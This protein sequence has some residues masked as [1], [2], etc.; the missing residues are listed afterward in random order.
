M[1]LK[2]HLVSSAVMVVGSTLVF[3]ALYMMNSDP[4]EPPAVERSE[5][6]ALNVERTPPKRDQKRQRAERKTIKQNTAAKL[7]PTPS[8]GSALAGISFRLPGFE[9]GDLSGVGND[10]VGAGSAKNMVMTEDAVDK[11]PAPVKQNPPQFPQKARQRGLEGY[12]KLNLFINQEGLVEKVKV[13]EAEPQGVFED[14]A[15]AAAQSWEFTPAEYNGNPV[16]GWFKR[17][18]SFRLN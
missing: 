5:A 18:V 13:L 2:R 6:I 15:I 17:T 9:S 14:S 10:M 4:G 1:S 8:L 3:G 11:K 7:A 12:V 16:T